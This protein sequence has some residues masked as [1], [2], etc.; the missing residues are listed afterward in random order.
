MNRGSFLGEV[1]GMCPSKRPDRLWSPRSF[2][3]NDM[4]PGLRRPGLDPVSRLRMS[5]DI[6]LR[7]LRR[8]S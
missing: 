4:G 1:R 5:G 7:L 8:I 3:P 6:I 2:L